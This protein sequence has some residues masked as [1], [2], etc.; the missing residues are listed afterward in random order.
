MGI[1]GYTY[2]KLCLACLCFLSCKKNTN[3]QTKL[4]KTILKQKQASVLVLVGHCL[5]SQLSMCDLITLLAQTTGSG[6]LHSAIFTQGLHS[7]SKCSY[8]YIFVVKNI[9]PQFNSLSLNEENNI[10]NIEMVYSQK[11]Y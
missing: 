10:S 5:L 7:L 2:P 4:N 6:L 8:L 9:I 11:S 1:Q 3:K